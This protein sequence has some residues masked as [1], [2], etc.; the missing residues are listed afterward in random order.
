MQTTLTRSAK[1]STTPKTLTRRA[2]NGTI[3][4]L[5]SDGYTE[6][7]ITLAPASC[8]CVGFAQ[9]GSCRHLAAAQA[10]YATPTPAQTAEVVAFLSANACHICGNVFA[11]GVD[12]RRIGGG[13]Y[14]DR[15]ICKLGDF[16]DHGA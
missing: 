7:A 12:S 2:T 3:F 16:N 13:Q 6:Y 4:A 14:L 11:T 5:S 8:A 1:P 9:R 10:R 15:P